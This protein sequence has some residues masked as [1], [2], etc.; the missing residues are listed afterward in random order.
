MFYVN[1]WKYHVWTSGDT[2]G[3]LN[4]YSKD[5]RVNSIYYGNLMDWEHW[6]QKFIGRGKWYKAGWERKRKVFIAQ[7]SRKEKVKKEKKRKGKVWIERYEPL[8]S[9]VKDRDVNCIKYCQTEDCSNK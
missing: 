2:P 7:K 6:M 4:N 5:L 1:S 9:V 8:R 3:A